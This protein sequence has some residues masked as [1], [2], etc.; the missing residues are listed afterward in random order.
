MDINGIFINCLVDTGSTLTVL[1]SRKYFAI[2]PDKRPTLLRCGVRLKMANGELVTTMGQAYFCIEVN[3][4]SFKQRF[5]VADIDVPAVL[6]YDF[7]HLHDCK[8][9]TKCMGGGKLTIGVIELIC[10]KES[11]M[12]TIFNIT[13]HKNVVLP[14]YSEV[15]IEGVIEGFDGDK[16]SLIVARALVDPSNCILPLRIVNTSNTEMVIYA[17]TR[18]ATCQAYSSVMKLNADW[19]TEEGIRMMR[20]V[21]EI[22]HNLERND[23]KRTP[24]R[25]EGGKGQKEGVRR[26]KNTVNSQVLTETNVNKVMDFNGIQCFYTNADSLPNKLGELM[27]RM[28]DEKNSYEVIGITEIYP[29]NCRYMPGKAELQIEGYE[30]FL[31][32]STSFSKRG[33]ALYIN[34]KLKSEEIK[35]KEK[36]DESVWAQIK[37]NNND[38]LLLG[39]IYK[40]PSSSPENLDELN[41]LLITVSKEKKFSHIMVIGEF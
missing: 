9:D 25:Q 21:D 4:K 13:V 12:T 19:E 2:S 28:Q 8:I 33:A 23:D 40:S 35:F 36:F 34:K 30:L 10:K 7:L 16:N 27:T 37:L 32:E 14:A 41:K 15:V 5:I 18:L 22:E 3:G 26:S 20:K 29:K 39:C 31:S 11:Q 38:M 1:H 17:N 24:R 6:G